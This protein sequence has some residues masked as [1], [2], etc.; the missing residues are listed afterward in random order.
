M[1]TPP[2]PTDKS[3][4]PREV[5]AAIEDDRILLYRQRIITRWGTPKRF[6]V[7]A[8]LQD[9]N[10]G[11]ILPG[12]WMPPLAKDHELVEALD[13]HIAEL[14]MNRSPPKGSQAWINFSPLS[15]RPGFSRRLGILMQQY[16][17]SPEQVCVEL[18]ERVKLAGNKEL[19]A[20][21]KLGC[22]LAL[23]DLGEGRSNWSNIATSPLTWLK[24]AGSLIAFVGI[25]R[26]RSLVTKY[27]IRL[28]KELRLGVVAECVETGPQFDRL[29]KWGVDGMQGFNVPRHGEGIPQ[30]WKAGEDEHFFAP[31]LD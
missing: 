27:L 22:D 14:V 18:N 11:I 2:H 17:V 3:Y 24:I 6:E 21:R 23:D 13:W 29:W 25:D 26:D 31:K 4:W 19:F 30:E 15:L 8:R 20:I 16:Q 5:R 9:R 7:L 12:Q 10:G 1:V 28:G